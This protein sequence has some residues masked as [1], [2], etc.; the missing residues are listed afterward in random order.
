MKY[1]VR[2]ARSEDEDKVYELFKVMHEENDIF[3]WDDEKSRNFINQAT[4]RRYGVIGVIENENGIEAMI[5]LRPDQVWY[6]SDWF[7]NEV[8]NFVHPD[9]RRSTRAKNL[10]AFAK[11]I[12]DEMQLPLILGEVL[13]PRTEAKVKLYERQFPKAGAFFMYNN[14]LTRVPSHG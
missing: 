3:S 9:Y 12:S 8:F 11:N 7:L 4:S 6:S 14:N 13:N 2:I 5:C 1:E 10:I